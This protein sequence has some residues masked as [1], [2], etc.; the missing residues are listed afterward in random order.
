MFEMPAAWIAPLESDRGPSLV[1]PGWGYWRIEQAEYWLIVFD[2]EDGPPIQ[3]D[4]MQAFIWR[5][6]DGYRLCFPH[7]QNKNS[8]EC[9]LFERQP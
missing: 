4:A 1:Y 6:A 8:A 7:G 9:A 3:M 2:I 5:E